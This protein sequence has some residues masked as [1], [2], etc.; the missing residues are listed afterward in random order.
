MAQ[1]L[2]LLQ[3]THNTNCN[4]NHHHDHSV[5]PMLTAPKTRGVLLSVALINNNINTVAAVIRG[6][7]A[8][9]RLIIHV[10]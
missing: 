6:I 3:N 8:N 10:V 7:T 1:E 5:P 9:M 4:F 2:G